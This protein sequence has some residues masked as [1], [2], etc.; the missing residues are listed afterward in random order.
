MY[1][2]VPWFHYELRIVVCDQVNWC[3]S[4]WVRWTIWNWLAQIYWGTTK[5]DRTNK[6][7]KKP[8]IAKMRQA[9]SQRDEQIEKKFGE[10]TTAY[11][12][13]IDTDVLNYNWWI[14]WLHIQPKKIFIL[15]HL[16]YIKRYSVVC[17]FFSCFISIRFSF[18]SLH[19]ISIFSN[20]FI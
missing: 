18:I 16:L 8:D 19:K 2:F 11:L 9:R 14:H 10:I 6:K 20:F 5:S 12:Y 3:D 1:S 15:L 7:Y 13:W 17:D 4:K